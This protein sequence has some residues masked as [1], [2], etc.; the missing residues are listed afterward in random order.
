MQTQLQHTVTH[1]DRKHNSKKQEILLGS[2]P[3]PTAPRAHDDQITSYESVCNKLITIYKTSAVQN[4]LY[5]AFQPS[6]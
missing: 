3:K 6:E 2:S 1:N 4:Q 5:Q